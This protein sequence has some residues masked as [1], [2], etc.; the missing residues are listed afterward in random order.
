[1]IF[2][3][4]GHLIGRQN[5]SLLAARGGCSTVKMADEVVSSQNKSLE[6]LRDPKTLW[7]SRNP[8]GHPNLLLVTAT[9]DGH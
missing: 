7:G 1:M 2:Q 9:H 8:I 6:P 4:E 5:P 3:N